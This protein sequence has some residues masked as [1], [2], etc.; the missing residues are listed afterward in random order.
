MGIRIFSNRYTSVFRDISF[1]YVSVILCLAVIF[2]LS[3]FSQ[4]YAQDSARKALTSH[5]LFPQN[6]A[7]VIKKDTI[8]KN[9]VSDTGIVKPVQ[10]VAV[11]SKADSIKLAK[12]KFDP[13]K[14]TIRSAIL[15]G[16]GQ[17]Y[18]HEY[19]KAPIVWGALAI[20]TA[21][22]F[23]NNSE[24]KKA[25]FAYN[26]I[27]AAFIIPVGQPGYSATDTAK[28]ASDYKNY[29]YSQGQPVSSNI[30][31]SVLGGIQKSRNYYRSNRDYSVLWFFILWGLQVVDAT[32][33]GHLKQFDVSPD[34]SMNIKPQ[35]NP[36][37][38][39]PGITLVVN[40]G[41]SDNY[42]NR[43]FTLNRYSGY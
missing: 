17:I 13:A 4:L 35:I 24:Y 37:T 27:Y 20:P 19:W 39:I 25:R 7:V 18:N 9:N 12:K 32:V 41:K 14:S 8:V 30:V 28:M 2:T 26:A 40:F 23:F 38:K 29:L 42:R 36:M 31:Q 6:N 21:T 33:F 3:S 16:W 15:P 10:P 43:D 11:L 22:F 34:L 5:N 1:S